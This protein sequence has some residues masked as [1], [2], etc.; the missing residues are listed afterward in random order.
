MM[1][2]S[3]TPASRNR[4]A[5]SSPPNPPPM[6]ITSTSSI[7]R[8]A[9]ETGLHVR[10]VEIAREVAVHL[11]ILVVAV[12]AQPLVAFLP[13]LLAQC[14]GIESEGVSAFERSSGVLLLN[15]PRCG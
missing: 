15:G 12:G 3:S 2:M 9:R 1:R 10:I 6:T 5:A 7:E 13:V 14:I 4:A 11:T 8:R